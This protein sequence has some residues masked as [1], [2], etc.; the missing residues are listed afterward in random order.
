MTGDR[1]FK[2]TNEILRGDG[3][4]SRKPYRKPTVLVLGD[5]RTLTLGGSPGA[6]DSTGAGGIE[7][8]YNGRPIIGPDGYP[9]FN[10]DGTIRDPDDPITTP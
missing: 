3:E 6:G 1:F 4:V 7:M 9:I 8:V 10:P 5:L 2:Q